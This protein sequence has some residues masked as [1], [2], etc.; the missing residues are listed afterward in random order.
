MTKKILGADAASAAPRNVAGVG[1][2]TNAAL[3]LGGR[4]SA[5]EFQT[6]GLQVC[7]KIPGTRANLP[8]HLD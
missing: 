8:L 4:G 7:D 3:Q 2:I 5:V 6:P 1:W